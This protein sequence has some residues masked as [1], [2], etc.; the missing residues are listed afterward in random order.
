MI[1]HLGA[2]LHWG[3]WHDSKRISA[4]FDICCSDGA[5]LYSEP[6]RSRAGR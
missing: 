6:A 4:T 1:E 2:Q 3:D 5:G